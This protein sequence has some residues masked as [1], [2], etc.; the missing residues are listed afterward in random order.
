[1][2]RKCFTTYDKATKMISSLRQSLAKAVEVLYESTCTDESTSDSDGENGNIALPPA[3]K[4]AAISV[5]SSS[6]S[7]DVLV[8]M[9]FLLY[10]Y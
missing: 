10:Y 9:L 4:R 8:N 5:L 3:P 7:P 2:C 1:M 6:T